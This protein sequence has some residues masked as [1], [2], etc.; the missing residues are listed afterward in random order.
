MNGRRR[1]TWLG[2]SAAAWIL[3]GL[4]MMVGCGGSAGEA[5]VTGDVKVDGQPLDKGTIRFVAT[6][7]GAPTAEAD[8]AAG[9]FTAAVEPGA[10]RVE[11]QAPKVTG[12]R[13]MYDTPESPTVD[14]VGESLPPRYNA[15]SE[16]TMTVAE[17][18]QEKSFD[19][20]TK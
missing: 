3:A 9:K 20:T 19:L 6:D 10:K 2:R 15:D 5:V 4:A 12:R 7:G 18:E 8:I 14:I 16:L 13:K 11:I 17:G 1:S